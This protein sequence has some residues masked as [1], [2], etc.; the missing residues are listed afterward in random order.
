MIVIFLNVLFFNNDRYSRNE[1]KK[2]R[3]NFETSA[4][5]RNAVINNNIQIDNNDLRI[6]TQWKCN[7]TAI[8]FV[9]TSR[10]ALPDKTIVTES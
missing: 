5:R 2:K 1:I 7:D 4:C 8:I 9:R 6:P 10:I 3:T